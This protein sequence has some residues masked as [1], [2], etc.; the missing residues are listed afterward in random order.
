MIEYSLASPADIPDLVTLWNASMPEGYRLGER[1]LGQILR[2]DPYYEAH[3]HWIARDSL[4]AAS[5]YSN[6]SADGNIIGWVLSKSMCKAGS[7]V[8]RFQNRGGIGALCVHPHYQRR[9]I[10]TQLTERAEAWLAQ[11]A[12]P[13]TLLYFPHQLL[14]GVPIECE[15]ARF[16]FEQRGYGDSQGATPQD[17][18]PWRECVDLERDLSDYQVPPEARAALENNVS[19][20]IRP[21]RE[22]E[23]EAIIAFVAGEFPGAWTYTTRSHFQQGGAAADFIIV[24]EA[25]SAD[26]S[27]SIIGFCHTCDFRSARLLANTFWLVER[28]KYFGGLGPIGVAAAHRKRGLGLALCA[29]A[30]DDL[31]RRGVQRMGIDWT[32]LIEFYGRMGFVVRRRYLQGERNTLS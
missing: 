6:E 21:A 5:S 26:D 16:F 24:S 28:E 23:S 11:N 20:R 9:G 14:P 4:R 25:D 22:D 32:N 13:Q 15:A 30:V 17:R 12:S 1:V 18:K 19:V 29:F 27:S 2:D 10:G 3:G 31:K 7:E 8:G